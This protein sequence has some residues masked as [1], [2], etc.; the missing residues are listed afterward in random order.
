MNPTGSVHAEY[1]YESVIEGFYISQFLDGLAAVATQE[2]ERPDSPLSHGAAGLMNFRYFGGSEVNALQ[3]NFPTPEEWSGTARDAANKFLTEFSSAAYVLTEIARDFSGCGPEY[4]AIIKGARDNLNAAAK[5]TADA[6][7]EKFDTRAESGVSFDFVGV[8]LGT[9][10]SVA[11]AFITG[12]AATPVAYT[13]AAALWSAMFSATVTGID[14][15]TVQ[16]ES[17]TISGL[18]WKDLAK[19]HLDV[20]AA[21]LADATAQINSINLK[22]DSLLAT[23]GDARIQTVIARYAT[24]P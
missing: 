3:Q 23:F 14:D 20:Q 1:P 15:T 11:A 22:L 9:I 6:F 18:W 13:T 12:G 19:S 4:A 10:A 24:M 7:Q 16:R 2:V 8:L 17:K 5:T 21:I